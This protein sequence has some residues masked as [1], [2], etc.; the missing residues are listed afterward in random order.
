MNVGELQLA[1]LPYPPSRK[2]IVVVEFE[3]EI[4]YEITSID[5]ILSAE[6]DKPVIVIACSKAK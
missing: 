2:V 1:L 4:D 3:E 5:E 6:D